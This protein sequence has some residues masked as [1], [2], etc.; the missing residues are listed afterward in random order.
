[1]RETVAFV[2]LVVVELPLLLVRV[3]AMGSWK[4]AFLLRLTDGEAD[5]IAPPEPVPLE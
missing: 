1:M 5:P 4:V 2:V 3:R